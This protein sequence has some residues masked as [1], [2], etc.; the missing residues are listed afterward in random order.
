MNFC[1]L[2]I[3]EPSYERMGAQSNLSPPPHR[4]M[5]RG[6]TDTMVPKRDKERHMTITPLYSG[7]DRFTISGS[8]CKLLCSHISASG[9]FKDI[10]PEQY[11]TAS[12][13]FHGGWEGAGCTEG[14]CFF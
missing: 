13:C 7:I 5:A 14:V 3:W 9:L 2:K 8:L 1:L 12:N 10:S 4:G 6:E 11:D